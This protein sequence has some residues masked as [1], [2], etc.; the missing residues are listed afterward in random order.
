VNRL[1]TPLL[2]LAA[3][4]ALAFGFVRE[5]TATS[6]TDY[7]AAANLRTCKVAD[8]G[9]YVVV[10]TPDGSSSLVLLKNGKVV[11]VLR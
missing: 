1:A 10:T 4:G 6:G 11:Q 5:F 8:Q 3:I 9:Q 7:C 2:V